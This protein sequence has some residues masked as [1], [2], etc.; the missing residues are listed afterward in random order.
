M[1]VTD[2]GTLRPANLKIDSMLPDLRSLLCDV[3]HTPLNE[4]PK[5]NRKRCSESG[6]DVPHRFEDELVIKQAAAMTS[7]MDVATRFA[8]ALVNA[9]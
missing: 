7:V 1:S 5:I 2:I 9:P 8:F 4:C 6:C 3:S